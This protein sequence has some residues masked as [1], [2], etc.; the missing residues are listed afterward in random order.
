MDPGQVA[1]D[2]WTSLRTLWREE[3]WLPAGVPVLAVVYVLWI[4]ATGAAF[5]FL[6]DAIVGPVRF[7]PWTTGTTVAVAVLGLLWVLGPAALVTVLVVDRVRNVNDNLRHGYRLG[8]PLFLLGPPATVLAVGY[9]LLVT[10]GVASLPVFAV[11]VAGALWLL[12]RTVAY[13]YR[14]FSLSLPVVAWLGVFLTAL[15][16][17]VS[18]LLAGA[19]AVGHEAAVAALLA[20]LADQTGIDALATLHAATVVVGGVDVSLLAAAVVAVPPGVAGAY[21]AVQ[22][23]WSVVV[24]LWRPSVRRPELRT[25]QRYPAFAR[26]TTHAAPTVARRLLGLSTG[27]RPESGGQSEG[28]DA[29]ADATEGDAGSTAGSHASRAGSTTPGSE[30][31]SGD[32]PSPHGGRASSSDGG[33]TGGAT[34]STAG[35]GDESAGAGGTGGPGSTSGDPA[36]DEPSVTDDVSNTRVFTPPDD[37]G[38]DATGQCP[39]CGVAVEATADT[40]P[41]CGA[42]IEGTD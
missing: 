40:C 22:L 37:A 7:D 16:V 24:R 34:G 9:G 23:P 17:A 29:G 1:D 6:G 33:S 36:A 42:G 4:G 32:S 2:A 41:D 28:A 35:A 39:A 26:P 11:L 20:G 8:H 21:L 15:V 5:S 30:P 12:V 25:G 38:L 19:T 13:A 27:Y 31:D 10:T 14:V 3:R 18:T